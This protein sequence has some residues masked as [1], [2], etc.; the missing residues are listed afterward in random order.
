MFLVS[1]GPLWAIVNGFTALGAAAAV[2]VSRQPEFFRVWALTKSDWGWVLFAAGLGAVLSYPINRRALARWGSDTMLLRFGVAGGVLLAAIPW[3][4]ALPGLLAGIFLQGAIYSGVGVAINHLA[5][6]WELEQGRR[7]MGRLHAMFFVGGVISAL[8]SSLLGAVGV[9]LTLHMAGVGLLAAGLHASAAISLSNRFAA[10]A[11][12]PGEALHK[13][14]HGRALGRLF[15]WCMVLEGGVMGWASV[16]LNQGLKASEGISGIGLAVFSGAMAVGRILSDRLVGRH[17]AA[18]LVRSGAA[19]CALALAL[20]AALK[21]LPVALLAFAATGFGLASAAPAVFSAA[22]RRSG[23]AVALVAGIGALGGLLGP[24]AL[25]RIAS[26]LSLDWVL[27]ALAA[28]GLVIARLAGAL[29]EPA[30]P[31]AQAM[32]ERIA[33]SR[34]SA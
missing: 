33:S 24:L 31:T 9:D 2:L 13:P 16:Y 18:A 11:P 6:K 7:M 14:D 26:A 27:A 19:L 34:E 20:A 22:G 30:T 1:T 10:V 4:P 21:Q 23:D 17:G 12:A 29:A 28:V 3:L 32:P 5:A 15:G 8:L 25:G